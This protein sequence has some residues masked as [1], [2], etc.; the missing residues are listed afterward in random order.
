MIKNTNDPQ[1][2]SK[3]GKW[4]WSKNQT[5]KNILIKR[6]EAF[7]LKTKK[8]TFVTASVQQTVFS[9]TS[10][11]CQLFFAFAELKKVSEQIVVK[12]CISF[13]CLTEGHFV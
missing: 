2:H 8:Q 7:L 12:K 11:S 4:L 13:Q 3:H 9:G 10:I 1:S 5:Q 6:L